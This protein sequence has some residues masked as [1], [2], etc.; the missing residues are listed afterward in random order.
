MRE[1]WWRVNV[2]IVI[3]VVVVKVDALSVCVV[4]VIR[5]EVERPA[6]FAAPDIPHKG[7]TNT[8]PVRV[9]MRNYSVF[10]AEGE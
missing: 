9:G 6:A 3:V 2:V 1:N 7:R 8:A 5:G 10:W 4:R